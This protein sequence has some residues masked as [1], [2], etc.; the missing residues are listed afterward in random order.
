MQVRCTLGEIAS[1]VVIHVKLTSS[2][3][4]DDIVQYTEYPDV[5]RE[6]TDEYLNHWLGCTLTARFSV[7]Q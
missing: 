5:L 3:K 1:E 2:L 4:S 7:V 6:S